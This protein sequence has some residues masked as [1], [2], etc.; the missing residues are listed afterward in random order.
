MNVGQRIKAYIDFK[1]KSITQVA[2]ELEISQG[3]L[4]RVV[5]G[6]NQPG[7]KILFPLAEA[8]VS[9]DWLLTGHGQM[10]R[11]ASLEESVKEIE[12]SKVKEIQ[13]YEKE[14]T[15]LKEQLSLKNEIIDSLRAHNETLSTLVESLKA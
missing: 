13:H 5:R 12:E 11:G 1:K 14:I 8:G 7:P 9:I 15:S 4:N 3:G 6:E 10:M 2:K